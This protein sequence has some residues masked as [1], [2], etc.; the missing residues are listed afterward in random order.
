MLTQNYYRKRIAILTL[1]DELANAIARDFIFEENYSVIIF[2][3]SEKKFNLKNLS[4]YIE[5]EL[6][7]IQSLNDTKKKIISFYPDIIINLVSFYSH[8][9]SNQKDSLWTLN[10]KLVE[11][12]CEIGRIYDSMIIHF[13]DDSVFDGKKGFYEEKS[14]PSPRSYLG[15][16]K[17]ATENSLKLGGVL[18]SILRLPSFIFSIDIRE[19]FIFLSSKIDCENIEWNNAI[20]SYVYF[21]DILFPLK[22][23]IN[24]G[25]TGVF[26]ICSDDGITLGDYIIALKEFENNFPENF[27]TSEIN[28]NQKRSTNA[29]NFCLSNIVSKVCLN[30]HSHNLKD[31]KSKLREKLFLN[32]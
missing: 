9:I 28:D 29:L 12:L 15:R 20:F 7:N 24:F 23:I 10:L 25:K 1:G 13:S 3:Q 21:Y 26:H 14:N 18:F 30:L 6:I 17:L 8:T 31:V 11:K 22:K 2:S 5:F 4:D 27:K 19:C 16:I 32:K